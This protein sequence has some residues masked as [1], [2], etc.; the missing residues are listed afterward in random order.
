[1]K[2]YQ[3]IAALEKAPREAHIG[4]SVYGHRYTEAH[5]QSH[6]PIMVIQEGAARVSINASLRSSPENLLLASD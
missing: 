1:M 6:G 4:L 5:R 2:V 3:L